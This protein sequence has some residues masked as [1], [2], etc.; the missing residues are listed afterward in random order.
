MK[1]GYE[2]WKWDENGNVF[3]GQSTEIHS[4]LTWE[5]KNI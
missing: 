2:N 1:N 4:K 3:L 5:E